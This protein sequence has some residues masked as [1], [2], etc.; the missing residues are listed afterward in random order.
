[1]SKANVCWGTNCWLV[2]FFDGKSTIPIDLSLYCEKGKK[3]DFGLTSKQRK[4]RFAKQRNAENPN[5]IRFNE[6]KGIETESCR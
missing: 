4:K 5:A 6:S 1:M 2:H 3:K